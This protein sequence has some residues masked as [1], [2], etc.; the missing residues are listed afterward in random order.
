MTVINF[1]GRYNR[2]NTAGKGF[3]VLKNCYLID[4][5]EHAM[6]VLLPD[7]PMAAQRLHEVQKGP[8]TQALGT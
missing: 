8:I 7:R 1:Y 2:Q 3:K 4:F 5:G 6:L